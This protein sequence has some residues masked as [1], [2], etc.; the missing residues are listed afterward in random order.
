MQDMRRQ[1]KTRQGKTCGQQAPDMADKGT[2]FR[3][4]STTTIDETYIKALFVFQPFLQFQHLKLQ[5][6]DCF[7]CLFFILRK[8]L[9][10]TQKKSKNN[11]T[12]LQKQKQHKNHPITIKTRRVLGRRKIRL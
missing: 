3:T 9:V 11:K 4:P 6:C 2:R 8:N 1:Q 10:N 5:L 7:A 12:L